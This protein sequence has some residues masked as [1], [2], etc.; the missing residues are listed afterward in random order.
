MNNYLCN[1]K[2]WQPPQRI[3]VPWHGYI[4]ITEYHFLTDRKA[5]TFLA[6]DHLCQTQP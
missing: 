6:P 2:A 5:H 1:D 3:Y 4:H